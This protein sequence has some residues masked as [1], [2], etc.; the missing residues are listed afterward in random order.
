M[1]AVGDPVGH[2]FCLLKDSLIHELEDASLHGTPA[3]WTKRAILRTRQPSCPG[4]REG[5]KGGGRFLSVLLSTP[6]RERGP[7]VASLLF[8]SALNECGRLR[9]PAHTC[10]CVY[11]SLMG[12]RV[13][14]VQRREVNT[15]DTFK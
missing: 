5:A 15:I 6:P 7:H 11:R 10:A 14:R 9:S 1:S 8:T 2:C 12:P 13:V 3:L 4:G